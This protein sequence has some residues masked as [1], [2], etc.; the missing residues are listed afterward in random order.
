MSTTD[1]RIRLIL[2]LVGKEDVK[3]AAAEA[4]ELA[5]ELKQVGIVADQAAKEIYEF[6]DVYDLAPME[7]ETK[8][9]VAAMERLTS[10]V[11]KATVAKKQMSDLMGGQLVGNLGMTAGAANTSGLAVL[12]LSQFMDDLQYGV[13]GVLN[14]IP[15]L[16]MALG[17]GPGLAGVAALAAVALSQLF[18][19]SGDLFGLWNKG[20]TE[21]ETER[22]RKLSEEY[23]KSKEGVKELAEEE[24]KRRDK[25]REAATAPGDEKQGETDRIKE[26]TKTLGGQ[27]VRDIQDVILANWNTRRGLNQNVDV[28]AQTRAAELLDKLQGNQGNSERAGAELSF[29]NYIAN[30]PAFGQTQF[31]QMFAGETPSEKKKREEAAAKAAEAEDRKVEML[32]LE[33]QRNEELYRREVEKQQKAE[34]DLAESLTQQGLHNELLYQQQKEA[35]DEKAAREKAAEELRRQREVDA[36]AKQ[37]LALNPA[38]EANI[39]GGIATMGTQGAEQQLAAFLQAQGADNPG[40][41][42]SDLVMQVVEKLMRNQAELMRRQQWYAQQMQAMGMDADMMFQMSLQ[43]MGRW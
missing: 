13:R 38:L 9:V 16:V 7:Q 20:D 10:G 28:A 35:A 12:Q 39:A 11:E 15:G 18:E 22:M 40:L 19:R 42:A 4:R 36:A 43:N 37:M 31:G 25:A 33:G 30:Q 3:G 32:N 26:I 24:E 41:L 8:N 2:E 1:E 27:A 21:V 17:G 5:K 14:N 6:A 34:D 23:R 29:R